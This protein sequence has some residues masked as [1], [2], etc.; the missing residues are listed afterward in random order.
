KY[1]AAFS[2]RA[3]Y[4]TL[5]YSNS[6]AAFLAVMTLIGITLWVREENIGRKLIYGIVCFLMLLTVLGSLSKGAWL[7]LLA[8]IILLV[9][10][11][12][13]IYRFRSVFY[14]GVAAG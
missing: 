3:I 7:I 2:G 4:S 8:G 14:L 6:T 12:P 9:I 11:M 5:Q 10:G 1:P 13:G